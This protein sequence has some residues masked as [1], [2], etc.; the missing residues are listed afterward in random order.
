MSKKRKLSEFA[1]NFASKNNNL[2]KIVNNSPKFSNYFN[3]TG[4]SYLKEVEKRNQILE[5][6]L[7]EQQEMMRLA[8]GVN[9]ER[10]SL[11]EHLFNTNQHH[12]RT[13]TSTL[14]RIKA[15]SKSSPS[16]I[17]GLTMKNQQ[18][19]MRKASATNRSVFSS[20]MLGV[21]P[22]SKTT[23]ISDGYINEVSQNLETTL[24]RIREKTFIPSY[25]AS[26]IKK[27][28]LSKQ[29]KHFVVLNN[30]WFFNDTKT[31]KKLVQE[32]EKLDN[33]IEI[34][35]YIKNFYKKD[36]YQNILTKLKDLINYSK[37]EVILP[38]GFYKQLVQIYNLL[39]SDF[40]ENCIIVLPLLAILIDRA[41]NYVLL[42]EIPDGR[43]GT[44]LGG[45]VDK[46]TKYSV[47][48]FKKFISLDSYLL[49]DF[50]SDNLF[51]RVEFKD[52]MDKV[53]LG[54]HS[55]LHGIANPSRFD[56]THVIQYIGI[57]DGL[58]RMG[59]IEI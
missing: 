36:N 10:I 39:N 37:T 30:G 21:G 58:I 28:P 34:Q 47:K 32:L 8:F 45:K 22:I 11:S 18:E 9:R 42:I 26:F 16:F 52:G 3:P 49:L 20:S 53:E 55:E 31:D 43:I 27:V 15:L 40:E 24:K 19:L 7:K 17:G 54:R 4:F 44:T 41:L 14:D 38:D 46:Y 50:I 25:P 23:F 2:N 5:S 33:L 6:F 59:R 56:D 51:Q 1:T 35:N 48:N 13:A 57:L 12:I 29:M